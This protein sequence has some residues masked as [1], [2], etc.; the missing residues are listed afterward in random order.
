MTLLSQGVYYVRFYDLSCVCRFVISVSLVALTIGAPANDRANEY[1][2]EDESEPAPPPPSPVGR[3]RLPLL[4]S[5]GSRPI[6][7][8]RG[9]PTKQTTSKPT[10]SPEPVISV[11]I[12]Q[13]NGSIA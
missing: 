13:D 8:S 12:N 1:D 10:E 7:G 4:N 6:V 3:G 11:T 2:Y 5:R 9:A